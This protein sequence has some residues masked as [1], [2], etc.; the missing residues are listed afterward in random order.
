MVN[1]L[2][3]YELNELPKKI[4]DYYIKLSHTQTYQS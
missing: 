3:I 2:I 1:K 4:L